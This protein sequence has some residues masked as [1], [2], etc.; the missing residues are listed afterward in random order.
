MWFRKCFLSFVN[1]VVPYGLKLMFRDN[2]ASHFN[3]ETMELA[4]QNNIYFC[5]LPANVKHLFQP[6]DVSVFA[7]FLQLAFIGADM[8]QTCLKVRR[9]A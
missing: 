8:T 5:M 9:D 3:M 7:P 2:L 6:L 1:S 4:R